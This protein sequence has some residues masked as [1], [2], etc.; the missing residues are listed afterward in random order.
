[1]KSYVAAAAIIVASAISISPAVAVPTISIAVLQHSGAPVAG[2]V[3]VNAATGGNVNYSG[4]TAGFSL[5]NI[6]AV[7]S[8]ILPQPTLQTSSID[9]KSVS[10][11][12]K[13][14]YIYITEQGLTSPL[15]KNYFLSSMTA[16]TFQ[17]S[18]LDVAEYTYISASNALWGGTQIASH[19]FKT[20]GSVA[21]NTLSPVL[22]SAYSE[23]A[24]FIIHMSGA[25]SVNDTINL[26]AKVPEPISLSIL[27]SGLLGL[28]IIS[29]RR[30]AA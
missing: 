26:T 15:G 5:V 2:D 20:I 28:G 4:S 7:G 29:R 13:Y 23:T 25:G 24:E 21:I 9:V 12:D 16:N 6:T 14:L 10:T 27:G 1:M 17:G 3:V 18:V 19:D 30:K 11:G 8:P 22:G